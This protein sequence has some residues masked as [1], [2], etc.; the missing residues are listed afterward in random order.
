MERDQNSFKV[1]NHP[2]YA[3]HLEIGKQGALGENQENNL[4]F[5]NF[6]QDRSTLVL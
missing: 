2:V 5:P 6:P 3:L 1:N 4:W